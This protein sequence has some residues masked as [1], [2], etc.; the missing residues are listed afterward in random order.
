[1]MALLVTVGLSVAA[2]AVGELVLSL[3]ASRIPQAEADELLEEALSDLTDR[4]QKRANEAA[5]EDH[6][7]LFQLTTALSGGAM[8]PKEYLSSLQPERWD[9]V[10][11]DRNRVADARAHGEEADFVEPETK[12]FLHMVA[13]A[14]K[15]K[16]K[17]KKS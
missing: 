14:R 13:E 12:I 6:V 7:K 1:M 16:G 17:G 4:D 15:K 3:P 2:F 9:A 5:L 8:G 11:K 10:V